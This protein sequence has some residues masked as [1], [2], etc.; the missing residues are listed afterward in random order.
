[1]KPVTMREIDELRDAVGALIK[2]KQA[3]DRSEFLLGTIKVG[4]DAVNRALV[5]YHAQP[6]C[7]F[8]RL[9]KMIT[10][11]TTGRL[12]CER[13]GAIGLTGRL[14]ERIAL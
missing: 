6:D 1:M 3:G 13:C 4:E 12:G 7:P 14:L 2:Q 10:T 11:P 9:G 5:A 8:C